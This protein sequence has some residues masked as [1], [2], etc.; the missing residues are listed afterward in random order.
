MQM[1]MMSLLLV[2]LLLSGCQ[3][4][5][6]AEHISSEFSRSEFLLGTIVTIKLFEGG[7]EA[8]LDQSF[9][10]LEE[11]EANL[12]VNVA[13]S[14][15]SL[16]NQASAGLD[17]HETMAAMTISEDT[18]SV[19]AAGIYYGALSEGAF[20]ISMGPV[21]DAW[22]IGTEEAHVPS[23]SEIAEKIV[24]VDYGQIILD[25]SLGTVKIQPDMVIN[26]GGIAKG[27]AADEVEEIL[28]AGGV[29][30]AIINLGGNVKVIG[31]KADNLP[32]SIGIQSPFDERNDYIGIL[33]VKDQT[34]VT[35]GDYE[36]YFEENGV[37]YHHIFDRTGYPVVT[38]V[39]SITV[40]AQSSMAADALST[41]L[42]VYGREAGIELVNQIN[43]VACIYVMKNKEV[44]LSSEALGST[45]RLTD[46]E[47]HL[48]ENE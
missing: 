22:Q 48:V 43:G 30:K 35:S 42:Y 5:A 18:Q 9:R 39:A 27:Y 12:S 1:K 47:F 13:D 16:L 6:E 20:D 23:P 17:S 31:E 46:N 44:Y 29:S 19:V 14:D 41:I 45:F 28:L 33:D 2:V 8:L 21:I 24:L 38:D 11:I 37:R 26:L 10:R 34:I 7:S 32:F 15:I 4:T 3:F 36:R 25:P 40:I